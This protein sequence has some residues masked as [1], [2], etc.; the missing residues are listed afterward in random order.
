MDVSFNLR[1]PEELNEALQKLAKEEGRSKNM[2]IVM[3]L[4]EYVAKHY[5]NLQ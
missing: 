4:K 2:E 3:I 1:I 5:A